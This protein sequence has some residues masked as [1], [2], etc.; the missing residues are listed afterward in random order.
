MSRFRMRDIRLDNYRCFNELQLSLE[1]DTTVIFA[2]NGGG[3]TALL[4]ALAMGIAEFQTGAT[5]DLKFDMVRDPMMRTL[6]EQ[7]QRE[8]VGPCEIEWTADVGDSKR[9]TWSVSAHPASGRKVSKLESIFDALERV[10]VPGDRWPLF[11]WYGVDR[12]RRLRGPR[13][14]IK[15]K[16]NRWEAYASA[17]DPNLD[18]APLMQWFED[19]TAGD[20]SRRRRDRP[21]CLFH[22]A[23]IEATVRVMPGVQCA[24]YDPRMQEPMVRF[25]NGHA[26]SWS[27]LTDG[28]HAFISLA[29]DI[30]RRSVMLNEFDGVEAP[31]LV[32][33]LVLIDEIALHMHPRRQ[34][35]VLPRLRDAFPRLQFVIT[36][37]SPQVLSSVENRHARWLIGKRLAAYVH[38]EGRDTNAILREHMSTDD[39]DEKGEQE[40]RRLYDAIDKGDRDAAERIHH[41]LAELWGYHDPELIRARG[42]MDDQGWMQQL[43]EA[44]CT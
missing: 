15:R 31:N 5:E 9:V 7:G 28:D 12:L 3:K 25:E 14:K 22:E 6:G 11:A 30:A 42:F 35:V 39:R 17:L 29:A 36:T 44:G 19:E 32:E 40:L 8:P 38:V 34:R 41:K 16:G 20:V 13:R 10:R 24:W 33:G 1:E 4:A 18:E 27:E 23:A 43:I 37:H 26:A 2:E 21:E